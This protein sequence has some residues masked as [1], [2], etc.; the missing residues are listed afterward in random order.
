MA[1]LKGKLID[2]SDFQTEVA[3]ANGVATS[4]SLS[5]TPIGS[6]AVYV[7]VNGLCQTLTNDYTISGT[8]VNFTFTPAAASELMVKYIKR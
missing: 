6:G 4:L 8:N 2:S 7:F 5:F 1:K 3:T